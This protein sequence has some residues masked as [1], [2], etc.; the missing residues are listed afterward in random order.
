M[1]HPW[2]PVDTYR[3][4]RLAKNTEGACGPGGTLQ[5]EEEFIAWATGRPTAAEP[6]YVCPTALL[7]QGFSLPARLCRL[8]ALCDPGPPLLPAETEGRKAQ[9]REWGQDGEAPTRVDPPTTH[10]IPI[11]TGAPVWPC[12]AGQPNGA[13]GTVTTSGAKGPF[14]TLGEKRET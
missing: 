13:L 8:W 3:S 4:T 10:L 5:E 6:G 7:A 1:C 2:N 9:S 12:R 11:L 14:F